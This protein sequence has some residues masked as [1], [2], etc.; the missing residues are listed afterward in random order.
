MFGFCGA[1]VISCGVVNYTLQ[2]F[3]VEFS[4]ECLGKGLDRF[5]RNFWEGFE[6]IW[7]DFVRVL[8]EY[9]YSFR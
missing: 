3:L 1:Q 6:W 4:K 7:V 8:K 9:C 2:G 5:G